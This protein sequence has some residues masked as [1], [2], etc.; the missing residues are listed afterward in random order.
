MDP[1][2]CNCR[3]CGRE[4]CGAQ[5]GAFFCE[6][7][8]KKR[9]W[10]KELGHCT[11]CSC[12]SCGASGRPCHASCQYNNRRLALAD[13]P[14]NQPAAQA[15]GLPMPH[16]QQ[17]QMYQHIEPP[18]Q[19]QPQ[20]CPASCDGASS[21]QYWPQIH[22]HNAAPPHQQQPQMCPPCAS[23]KGGA[24]P[25]PGNSDEPAWP[26]YAVAAGIDQQVA[27]DNNDHHPNG[28]GHHPNG[29]GH[30]PN[31]EQAGSG[32]TTEALLEIIEG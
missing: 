32:P 18:H 31:G 27:A 1:N 13:V 17:P 16:Q 14:H 4:G 7:P 20:M 24:S 25:W 11:R 28:E 30:H 5:W 21:S 19:H 23:W 6:Q 8:L 22:Q 9:G 2:N 29:E 10:A 15:P 26:E 12:T 3:G